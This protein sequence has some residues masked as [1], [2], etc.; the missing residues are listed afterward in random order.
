MSFYL[1]PFTFL[2]S[3]NPLATCPAYFEKMFFLQC[4]TFL[5]WK[6]CF[7]KETFFQSMYGTQKIVNLIHSFVE[8]IASCDKNQKKYISAKRRKMVF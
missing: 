4:A 1:S 5:A 6:G 7:W 2:V 3:I 8:A